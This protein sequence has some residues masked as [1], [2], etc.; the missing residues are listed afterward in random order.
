MTQYEF[1]E[2][3]NE[4]QGKIG[5]NEKH[6]ANDLS[7]FIKMGIIPKLENDG[8]TKTVFYKIPIE[9]IINNDLMTIEIG[10]KMLEHGWQKKDNNFILIIK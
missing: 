8:K 4:C 7:E 10:F 2:L 6:L 9:N 1:D 5:I 3:I